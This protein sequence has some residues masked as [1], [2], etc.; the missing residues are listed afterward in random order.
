[1]DKNAKLEKLRRNFKEYSIDGYLI[2]TKDEFLNEYLPSCSKRL[3]YITGFS[4][5]NGSA[6]I[7][8]ERVI[9]LTDGR[10]I[11][12]AEKQIEDIGGV[13]LD[14]KNIN[15]IF[16]L[17]KGNVIGYDPKIM[18]PI[19]LKIFGNCSLKKIGHNLI[20]TIWNDK[21]SLPSSLVWKYEDLYTGISTL[22]K[23]DNI[24]QVL[25]QERAEY[26]CILSSSMVNWVLNIRGRD[27]ENSPVVLSYLL[28]GMQE[29][30]LFLHEP[31]RLSSDILPDFVNKIDIKDFEKTIKNLN[32]DKIIIDP[33]N[34]NEHIY[35]ILHESK[36]LPKKNFLQLDR[37]VKND[38][39][40]DF[41][42]KT[43]IED[44]IAICEFMA[45]FSSSDMAYTEYELSN[46]L[47]N[48]RKR[49]K[50]YICDS[51]PSIIGF[52]ENASIIHYRP[53]E[54]SSKK[55]IGDGILLIDSG[56][57]YL[58]G[59]TDVTR[60]IALGNVDLEKKKI[61]MAVLKGHI[62][63]GSMIFKSGTSGMQLDAIARQY[64]W[65]MCKD[66]P[67]GTGHGVGNCLDV[68]EGPQAIT[69][70]ND[71]AL[72]PNMILSNEPG[73]YENNMFGIRIENL[74]YITHVTDGY[75]RFKN[76]TF[77][78]Y[79]KDMI[80]L[81]Q[82]NKK[83]TDYI[84]EYYKDINQHVMHHLSDKAKLWLKKELDIFDE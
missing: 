64:L 70:I 17:L 45:W 5:S 84:K 39:E 61:Y 4:G 16:D 73:Y 62:A 63:M 20:D 25:S 55:V 56:G 33:L 21:P 41:A 2:S 57:H 40:I 82:L 18:S 29:V 24:R 13:V 71:V 68:H 50:K 6:I 3:E 38:K 66:Y 26:C 52:N 7:L 37:A 53:L 77:V 51:F 30:W 15:N 42:F 74:V 60:T 12:Q 1:M 69:S 67:H 34:S 19:F 32:I 28:I 65:S 36:I 8:K 49:S 78:P 72:L 14:Y 83:E 80:L 35:D 22:E 48:Y 10:Y 81:N 47:Q 46:I 43:H 11:L 79:N 54:N 76:L 58:G 9:L 75:L 59:T 44:A 23:I 27:L 31:S